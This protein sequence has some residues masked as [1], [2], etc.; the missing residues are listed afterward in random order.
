LSKST[1]QVM[2]VSLILILLWIPIEIFAGSHIGAGGVITSSTDHLETYW[3]TGL[4][5]GGGTSLKIRKNLFVTADL[6]YSHFA[7]NQK[8]VSREY[9]NGDITGGSAKIYDFI[10]NFKARLY[11]TEYRNSPYIIFGGGMIYKTQNDIWISYTSGNAVIKPKN[12]LAPL[13]DFGFGFDLTGRNNKGL[14]LEAKY[15]FGFF[16]NPNIGFIPIRVGLIF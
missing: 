8:K 9:F 5:I 10:F 3:Q 11:P 2:Q 14:F 1:F 15:V 4:T 16:D 7:L 6:D 13:Y 12:G